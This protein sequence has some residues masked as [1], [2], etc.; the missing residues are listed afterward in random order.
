M[1]LE[2]WRRNKNE[3]RRHAKLMGRRPELREAL[4][5]GVTAPREEEKTMKDRRSRDS[6]FTDED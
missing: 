5:A 2:R 3:A 1:K 6:E 4:Y